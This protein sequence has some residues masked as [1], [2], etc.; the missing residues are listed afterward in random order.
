MRLTR[1]AA[2]FVATA[3]A[4]LLSVTNAYAGTVACGG[5][6][7][8]GPIGANGCISADHIVIKG[9]PFRE[10]KAHV[11]LRN[12]SA[13][14]VQVEYEAFLNDGSGDWVKMGNGR[15]QVPAKKGIGPIQV[16]S[17]TRVCAPHKV[18]IRVH[19][20]PAGG[21]WSNWSPAATSQCST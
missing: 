9:S 17:Q 12:T 4:M 18:T 19:V 10:I 13:H 16:G 7:S 15:A 5:S 11:Q 20:R 21:A 8:T 6:V 1:I 14:A 3:V 2:L